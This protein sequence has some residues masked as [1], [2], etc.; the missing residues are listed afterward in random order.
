LNGNA[1]G[2]QKPSH[3][4]SGRPEFAGDGGGARRKDGRGG[5]LWTEGGERCGGA[6]RR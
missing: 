4:R 3:Y 1:G 6:G 5:K 2:H